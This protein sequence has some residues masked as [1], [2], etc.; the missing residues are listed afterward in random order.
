MRPIVILMFVILAS[1]CSA[2]APQADTRAADE[3]AIRQLLADS[4]AGFAERDYDKFMPMYADDAVL[5]FPNQ[6]IMTGTDAI[7]SQIAA[8]MGDPS[9]SMSIE[10]VKVD[11]ARSG[12]L[13]YAYGTGV[14]HFKDAES[15]KMM[16]AHSKW[17][18]VFRKGADGKWQAVADI[19]NDDG[20]PTAAE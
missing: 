5:F 19:F 9:V 12:D 8:S 18:T 1:A 2:E 10:P 7:R 20:P 16:E 3:A 13:A 4:D 17:V 11:V 14:M 15:G 6:P